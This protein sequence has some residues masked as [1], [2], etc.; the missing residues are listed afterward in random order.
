MPVKFCLLSVLILALLSVAGCMVQVTTGALT[1]TGL[2]ESKL[3]KG[4]SSD[5]DVRALLGAPTGFGGAVLPPE[6]K[7]HNIWFYQS[8]DV[9]IMDGV[10]R[11]GDAKQQILMIFFDKGIYD[12]HLWYSNYG[13]KPAR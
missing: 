13:E 7:R 6:Y 3:K 4:I 2:I 9:S 11:S 10:V 8:M 1:D 12:G 5:A